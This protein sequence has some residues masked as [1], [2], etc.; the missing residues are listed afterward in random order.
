MYL[1]MVLLYCTPLLRNTNYRL[2]LGF[3]IAGC[4]GVGKQNF[5]GQR[6]GMAPASLNKKQKAKVE[7]KK[8]NLQKSEES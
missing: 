6:K 5:T 7:C 4:G 8:K 3:H 1:F 2:E